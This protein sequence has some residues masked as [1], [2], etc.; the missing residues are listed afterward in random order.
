MK[1]VLKLKRYGKKW[2]L[3]QTIEVPTPE[4]HETTNRLGV[5]VGI[6]T[7]ASAISGKQTLRPEASSKYTGVPAHRPSQTPPPFSQG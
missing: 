4:L 7:V 1:L 5:D 6:A 2:F 3:L